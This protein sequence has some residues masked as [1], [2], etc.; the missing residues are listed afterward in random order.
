MARR[1]HGVHRRRF[2]GWSLIRKF[3]SLAL[4]VAAV[5]M[6]L[7]LFFR[8]ETIRVEGQQHYTQQEILAASG[9]E[10]GDNLYLL[11]KNTVSDRVFGSLPYVRKVRIYRELP[12]TLVIEI[13]ESAVAGILITPEGDWVL[14]AEGKIME[15]RESSTE[16]DCAVIDGIELK[17]PAVG[18]KAATDEDSS[19]RFEELLR[20]LQELEKKGL[21][22]QVQ[23]IHLGESDMLT[24]DYAERFTVCLP[25]GA[26]YEYK[27][28]SLETV[29]AELEDNETGTIDMLRSDGEV[30]F[31]P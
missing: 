11:N 31:Y 18:K 5:V 28:R 17:D 12:S 25:W 15:Q 7:I 24:M 1:R 4:G 22:S 27:L 16:Y 21:L 9:V 2:G 30:H 8:I 3:V 19:Y 6:A 20:L 23:A 10:K 26:D 29:I 13:Q 14:N